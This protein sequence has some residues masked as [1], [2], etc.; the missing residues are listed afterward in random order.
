MVM[1]RADGTLETK[2]L[3]ADGF[4]R[5]SEAERNTSRGT[6]IFSQFPFFRIFLQ[7]QRDS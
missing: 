2:R 5:L 7:A 3:M 4:T 6:V 1:S